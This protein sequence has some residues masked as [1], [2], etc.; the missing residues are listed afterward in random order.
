MAKETAN[1]GSR[2]PSEGVDDSEE[3]LD[4]FLGWAADTGFLGR[5]LEVF[6]K[7]SDWDLVLGLG[8]KR[9]ATDLAPVPDNALLLDWAP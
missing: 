6:V 3:I 9:T 2:V 5:V 1:L 7:R 4:L 8:G